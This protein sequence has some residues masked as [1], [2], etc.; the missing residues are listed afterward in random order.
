MED[1]NKIEDNGGRNA[2]GMKKCKWGEKNI[3]NRG[4][5]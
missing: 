4:A 1:E 5:R 3:G 2:N